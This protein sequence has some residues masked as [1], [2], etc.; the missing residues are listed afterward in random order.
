MP[1]EPSDLPIEAIKDHVLNCIQDQNL[2]VSAETGSGK[3][4]RL[5]IWAKSQG[6]VLVVEPRRIACLALAEYLAEGADSPVG[7]RVGYAVRF[8][9]AFSDNTQI[10]FVTPGV[11]LRWLFEDDLKDYDVVML[12]EFH[13]RRWDTDLLLAILNKR[14]SHRL[15]LTSATLDAARLS[16]YTGATTLNATGR[17]YPITTRYIAC[18]VRQMPS[19]EILEGRIVQAVNLAL[20]FTS[21]P[22]D[23]FSD[24]S[25][26]S[27]IC[28]T[29]SILGQ[30][31]N[32]G[33]ILVFLP[34][35][36]EIMQ[37]TQSLST[38]VSQ[39]NIDAQV[40]ALHAGS[41]KQTQQMALNKQPQRR[42][43]LATNVAETSLTIPNISCVIDSG[44]ERRT[45]LR[46]GRTVLGLAP[47]AKSSAE[48]R[49]GRAGRVM[50]GLCIRLFGEFA[51]LE[52]TTPAQILREDL[53]E[54][55]LSSA[56]AGENIQQL[57]FLDTL[58]Q[59]SLSLALDG[60]QR[61]DAIDTNNLATKHG[62]RIYPL[63]LDSHLAHLIVSMPTEEL[64]LAMIDLAAAL[65]VN[66][67]LYQ[68]PTTA[69][70]I[71]VLNTHLPAL[72]D[73]ELLIAC[74]R[75]HT[76]EGINT[77][78]LLEVNKDAVKEARQY[79]SQ[80]RSAFSLPP[81]QTKSSINNTIYDRQSL[82]FAI[83]KAQPALCFVKREKN[84]VALGNGRI[85]VSP[86][87]ESRANDAPNNRTNQGALILSTHALPGRGSKQTKTLA[88]CVLPIP[89]SIL[90]TLKLGNVQYED[91]KL[92]D[93][94]IMVNRHRRY[95]GR[96]IDSSL[97][98]VPENQLISA[99]VSLIANNQLYPGLHTRI[100]EDI[101]A[102]QLYRVLNK[103][104]PA[105]VTADSFIA[106]E[107]KSLGIESL[108]D[109]SLIEPDDIQFDGIPSWERAD[110]DVS[111]PMQVK[112]PDLQMNVEYLSSKK[113]IRLHYLSGQR[114]TEPKRWELPNFNGWRIQYKRASKVVDIR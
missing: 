110:F 22:T 28:G 21:T 83:A 5:P 92:I 69:H 108:E 27:N 53:T 89:L 20:A 34:G 24:I 14:Q 79:A 17:G 106:G 4:T 51:P 88:T 68:L 90:N 65:C 40:L 11:A 1:F 44:L 57:Q 60:L 112:L 54:M 18:D 16:R 64:T 61:I 97:G 39:H 70:D 56:C 3:S 105:E 78:E 58:P 109:L 95:A 66:Q 47:I 114:K 98:E 31:D 2:I 45:H 96:L 86:A 77:A 9:T 15:I 80:I 111:Y 67:R 63:P 99:I 13:E 23:E 49:K 76:S 62:E 12:D 46:G 101:K 55:V 91:I 72:C 102:F 25:D 43:I 29:S 71:E 30:N 6:R 41:D 100:T 113:Q 36:K 81:L 37:A 48:Q 104:D 75:K 38:F 74:V 50:A 82:C 87:R 103:Q 84:P 52:A 42:I 10:V 93:R 33:D 59:S 35:K 8:D 94:Q 26:T 32:T 7:D 85:E 73:G 107:L 19:S